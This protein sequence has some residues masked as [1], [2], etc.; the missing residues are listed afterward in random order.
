MLATL[1]PNK[2]KNYI[3]D[4][5]LYLCYNV[6]HRKD[7]IFVNSKMTLSAICHPNINI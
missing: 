3:F 2:I 4:S 1:L 6:K 5:L 7:A